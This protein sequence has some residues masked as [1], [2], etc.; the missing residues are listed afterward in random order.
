MAYT[1]NN[2][3]SRVGVRIVP[4]SVV[5]PTISTLLDSYSGAAAA[6]SLRKLKSSYTGYAI[7]VRRSSDNTE[8]DIGFDSNGNLDTVALSVFVGSGSGFV[9]TWY[10]Q[11]GNNNPL[12]KNSATNQPRIVNSGVVETVGGKPAVRWI[13]IGNV[14]HL[15]GL[16]TGLTNVCSVF[17]N[18]T[19]LSGVGMVPLLGHTTAYDYHADGSVYLSTA[20]ASSYVLNGTKY[21]NGV[22]KTNAT[23]TKSSSNSLISMI[24]TSASGRVNQI[25]SDR[26]IGRWFDG[27]YSE[28]IL[29]STDQTTNRVGI[30]SNINTYYSIY[31]NPTSVWNL[32]TA[33]YS[34]D[35]T[36]SPSLK[37]S[38]VASYN[39]ESNTNDSKGTN[40]G[41]AVG[42]LSYGTGKIGNAFQFN[43][44]NAYVSLT[45]SSN[46]TGNFSI[47]VWI[48]PSVQGSYNTIFEDAYLSTGTN[49]YGIALYLQGS[50]VK[51]ATYNG[52]G[53]LAYGNTSTIS[54]NTWQHIV[55]TKTTGNAWKMYINNTL[56]SLITVVGDIT[57]NPGVN[58]NSQANIGSDLD[59]GVRAGYFNGSIDSLNIWSKEL[60]A[61]EVSELYN[62]GN[63]AQ[64]ITDSFYKP[65]TNDALG[66]NNGT[67]QGGLTYGVG[68]VGTAFQFNGSNSY[69]SLPNNSFKFTGN[70]SVS[71][72]FYCK[73]SSNAQ[74]LINGYDYTG[75]LSGGWILVV[76]GTGNFLDFQTYINTQATSKSRYQV[77]FNT[78]AYN[79][80]WVHITLTRVSSTST[81]IYINGTEASGSFVKGSVADNPTYLTNCYS[82]IGGDFVTSGGFIN[83]C[84]NG[85]KIDAVNV[86]QKELSPAEV[87][88]LYNSGNGKQYPN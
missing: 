62:S 71:L 1:N 53:N 54:N 26:A 22:S 47:S 74:T 81:K 78:S 14:E 75:S 60:T 66:T 5:I 41:T 51:F 87:T 67:A 33:V 68:K 72:W 20:H 36:A 21:I 88:E 25:S 76:F 7:R 35:T 24:H 16:T 82:E 8:Q 80:Q 65:T 43:G 50:R 2:G 45:N 55:I 27:Y 57:T 4:L 49:R 42:G 23:F 34:A 37:T 15:M 77:G 84:D 79:N 6:Y 40:N 44:T 83:P 12:F 58:V 46:L 32:L 70:F 61:S 9:K 28:I 85:T 73:T 11:S 18:I 38:L 29:Y 17:L 56:Q 31:P 19:Y 63:G 10:D 59:I 86:W 30:E 64:Y 13:V 39:G 69:V 52:T 3:Q 48:N